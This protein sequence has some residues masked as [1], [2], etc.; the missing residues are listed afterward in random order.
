MPPLYFM[1]VDTSIHVNVLNF[2]LLF[3]SV[4]VPSL[5]LLG[6]KEASC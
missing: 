5:L 2:S 6:V 3:S 4:I 1:H